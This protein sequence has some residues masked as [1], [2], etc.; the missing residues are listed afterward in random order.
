M[1]LVKALGNASHYLH[2]HIL[3]YLEAP[4]SLFLEEGEHNWIVRTKL[5]EVEVSLVY[6]YDI[7]QNY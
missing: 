5:H 2:K 3:Q 7:P 1:Y 4:T 6:L